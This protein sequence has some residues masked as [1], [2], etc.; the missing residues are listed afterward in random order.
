MPQERR[1]RNL[2]RKYRPV[3]RVV[4]PDRDRL[5]P[6]RDNPSRR[7]VNRSRH[8]R[9][10]NNRQQSCDQ[11]LL[12]HSGVP[13]KSGLIQ[14]GL[15]GDPAKVMEITFDD[16]SDACPNPAFVRLM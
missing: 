10:H 12:A 8:A 6:G 7:R 5:P 2:R 1:R 3:Q 9:R 14:N 15:P 11:Q 16:P 13:S 4:N